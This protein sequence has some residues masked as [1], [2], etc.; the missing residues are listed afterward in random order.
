VCVCVRVCVCVC[1][2]ACSCSDVRSCR[3]L[4]SASKTATIA[5]HCF[6]A[7]LPP[8][9]ESRH[10][11]KWVMP[12]MW[13]C[14]GTFVKE[15]YH[16]KEC[17]L[18]DQF[19]CNRYYHCPLFSRASA[20]C[21]WVMSHVWM[22]HVTRV[23]WSRHTHTWVMSQMWMSHI[24]HVNV[25]QLL[26]TVFPRFC[27]RCMSHVTRKHEWVMSHFWTRHFCCPSCFPAHLPPADEF[28]HKYK[29]VMSHVWLRYKCYPVFSRTSAS[30]RRVTS[31]V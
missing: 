18:L 3:S 12:H 22:S 30:W 24:T 4:I 29:W 13:M 27:L 7:L 26:P 2:C 8:V 20:S 14:H 9:D 23:N 5:A 15:S 6:P 19:L 25:I 1:V 17:V 11:N 28:C 21:G 16:T 10:T 31:R